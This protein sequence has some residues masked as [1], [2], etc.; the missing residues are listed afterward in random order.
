MVNLCRIESNFD[1][2]GRPLCKHKF[3]SEPP[4]SKAPKSAQKPSFSLIMIMIYNGKK[5]GGL[6]NWSDK[7]SVNGEEILSTLSL[8]SS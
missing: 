1:I 6:E 3:E 8:T 7:I 4:T 2:I 5:Y